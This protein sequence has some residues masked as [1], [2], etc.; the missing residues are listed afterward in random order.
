MK[1]FIFSASHSAQLGEKDGHLGYAKG[2]EYLIPFFYHTL[3]TG[4][5]DFYDK[6][7]NYATFTAWSGLREGIPYE[8]TFSKLE[9]WYKDVSVIYQTRDNQWTSSYGRKL[10]TRNLDFFT[11][12]FQGR[13]VYRR[14][15]ITNTPEGS[16]GLFFDY[17]TLFGS[18][19]LILNDENDIMFIIGAEV[20][21]IMNRFFNTDSQADS[22]FIKHGFEGLHL[23][24]ST[25]FINNVLYETFIISL[26]KEVILPLMNKGATLKIASIKEI[27]EVFP[28][29]DDFW[30][31]Q[32]LFDI[33]GLISQDKLKTYSEKIYV[34]SV[35]DK[36]C[37]DAFLRDE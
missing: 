27:E 26:M 32:R 17:R 8:K 30:N 19:G 4:E 16:L 31:S 12:M 6:D 34:R 2:K 3:Y 35:V 29:S 23:F 7:N 20:P 14:F 10:V 24:L 28:R 15:N 25:E 13:P 9:E 11:M 33:K 5:V 37:L 1:D 36:T 18:Q 22:S 21:Y